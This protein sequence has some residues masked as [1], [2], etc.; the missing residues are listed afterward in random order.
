MDKTFVVRTDASGVGLGA[1]LMQY[2]EDE[3]FP[4][5]YAS[6][7][8]S[9]VERRYSTIERE[10]LAIIFGVTKFRYYLVGKE[11][12]LEVDHQPLT[13]LNNFK[14]NNSRIMRWALCLQAYNYRISYIKGSENIGADL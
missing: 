10:C 3:P 2:F 5:A 14:G 7:K 9:D 11:F 13:Y 12:V 1:I 6:R 4:I 8:L